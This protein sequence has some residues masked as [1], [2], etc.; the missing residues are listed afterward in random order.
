MM[1]DGIN[2]TTRNPIGVC[3]LI[4]PWNLPLYL[5][6]WKVGWCS[7]VR[8]LFR[9]VPDS[10]ECRWRQRL[11]WEIVSLQSQANSRLAPPQSSRKSSNPVRVEV[12]LCSSCCAD[13]QI[14]KPF[15]PM[16]SSLAFWGL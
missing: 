15:C 7:G 10:A 4:T 5:L 9:R 1:S 3:G 6:S 16:V 13:Q 11:L 2:Y 12:A 14:A 8:F